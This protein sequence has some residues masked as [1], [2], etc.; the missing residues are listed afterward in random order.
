MSV[1]SSSPESSFW[2]PSEAEIAG[3][4]AV[5]VYLGMWRNMATAARTSNWQS[6]LLSQ[7]A[8]GTALTT[9]SR[10]L[11][12]DH[13]NGLVTLGEPKLSPSVAGVE[14]EDAPTLVRISDCGDS[15]NWLKYDAKT[16]LAAD[17]GPGGRRSIS[18][19]VTKQASGQWMVSDFA[20]KAVGTC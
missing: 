11:Y 12:T 13:Q 1:P 10:G 17:D 2:K 4:K 6:P 20:V 9:I 15:T 19:V 3:K 16:R 14:P 5:E 18:A 8:T 7:F